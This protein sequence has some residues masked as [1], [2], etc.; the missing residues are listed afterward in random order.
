MAKVR[1][2]P[3]TDS[4]SLDEGMAVPAFYD[5]ENPERSILLNCF[6]TCHRHFL[7]GASGC[8]PTRER[9]DGIAHLLKVLYSGRPDSGQG[10][11]EEP[12]LLFVIQW[13]SVGPYLYFGFFPVH[14]DLRFIGD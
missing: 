10:N 11:Y 4:R 6:L 8:M 3:L 14:Y 9:L 2:R 13:L 7:E 1:Y 5:T 12:P